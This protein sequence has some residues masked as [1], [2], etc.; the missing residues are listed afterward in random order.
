MRLLHGEAI[1]QISE[2]HH[3]VV[4]DPFLFVFFKQ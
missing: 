3:G 2:R 4:V 1:K